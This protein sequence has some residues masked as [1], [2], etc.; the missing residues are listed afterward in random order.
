MWCLLV[1]RFFFCNQKTAYEMRISDWSS[2][3]C[4]SDLS[5]SPGKAPGPKAAHDRIAF[6]VG[7]L[8]TDPLVFTGNAVRPS[9]VLKYAPTPAGA[10]ASTTPAIALSAYLG[11]ARPAR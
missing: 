4:S 3:V 8:S 1:S 6:S 9:I 11:P 5:T 2:D 7:P 10:Q